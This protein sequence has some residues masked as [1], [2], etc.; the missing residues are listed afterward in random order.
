MPNTNRS[1]FIFSF[2]CPSNCTCTVVILILSSRLS[3]YMPSHLYFFRKTFPLLTKLLSTSF[4]GESFI[5]TELW[6]VLHDVP[7]RHS[8]ILCCGHPF[9]RCESRIEVRRKMSTLNYFKRKETPTKCLERIDK[10]NETL[11]SLQ[12]ASTEKECVVTELKNVE[13]KDD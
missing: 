2:D 10:N 6:N 7:K 9:D 4:T 5:F 1:K 3:V 11:S 13:S 8:K 12:L